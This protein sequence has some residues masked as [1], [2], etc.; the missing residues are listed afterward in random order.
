MI[1]LPPRRVHRTPR[2]LL[3][4]AYTIGSQ[5]FQSPEAKEW[6]SY[7]VT[8]RRRLHEINPDLY[9]KGDN[10]I[11]FMGLQRI[12]E[13]LFY[14]PITHD[15]ISEAKEFLQTFKVTTKGLAPYDFP[16]NLWR[17][18]V[19]EFGG[20]PPIR[21]MGMPE[22]SV[23]YPNEPVVVV[24]NTVKHFGEFAAW[25]ESK[26]LQV[27][28]P[29]ERVTQSQHWLKQMMA[30]VDSI[31][32]GLSLEDRIFKA[33]LMLHDFGDRAG[34]GLE[35]SEEQG[36]YHGY[37]FPGTDTVSGAYQGWKNSGKTPGNGLSVLALAHR[38]VQA[39]LTEKQCYDHMYAMAQNGEFLSMVADCYDFYHAVENY[40]LPLALLAKKEGSGK[41]IV[42]R[43]DSGDALEQVTWVCRLAR[44]HGLCEER[45]IDGKTWYFGTN[46]RFI[47]GDGMDFGTMRRINDALIEQGF[48][49]YAW[50]LYGVGGGLRNSLKRDNL[51]AKYALCAVG[52]RPVVKFSETL[53]KTT[54]PGPF[55]VMRNYEALF[56]NCETIAFPNEHPEVPDAMV[57]YF[58]GSRLDKPFGPGM[59]DDFLAI[60]ERIKRQFLSGT[61]P[62]TL[63]TTEN[64][65]YPATKAIRNM[66]LALLAKYAPKKR[67]ENY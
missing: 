22:G 51:S 30:M 13:K 24:Q 44:H 60:K 61:M 35:E 47:E 1:S 21:V 50:G 58:D 8:Y 37:T 5:T 66:R 36:M 67:K 29:T 64:H 11:V 15:E 49:P 45:V 54:L 33:S 16:E 4:D 12:L 43:P 42:A 7:Y 57:E 25:F 52:N 19:D 17:L 9:A 10:R 55:K 63:E 59:D 34:L 27:W 39:F 3:A 31:E 38:N 23:V 53:G 28:G 32:P 14:E 62:L 56:N 41:V 40:L 20:R 18:V 65:N 26:I 6:S 2:P 46:L 48:P